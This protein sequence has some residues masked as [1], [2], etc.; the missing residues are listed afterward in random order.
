MI[1][2][3][4]SPPPVGERAIGVSAWQ[5]GAWTQRRMKQKNWN[6]MAAANLSKAKK[7]K[8]STIRLP[9]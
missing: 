4:S 2:G 3:Y 6:L 5:K 1:S 7:M 8:V 9:Q